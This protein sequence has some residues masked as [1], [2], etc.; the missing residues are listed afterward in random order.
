[1]SKNF[2]DSNQSQDAAFHHQLTR[3]QFTLSPSVLLWWEDRRLF[4]VVSNSVNPGMASPAHARALAVVTQLRGSSCASAAAGGFLPPH[5]CPAQ[6][7][8]CMAFKPLPLAGH[9]CCLQGKCS[10]LYWFGQLFL[11]YF[12]RAIV[13]NWC[14]VRGEAHAGVT[15]TAG[16]ESS[17]FMSSYPFP[18]NVLLV[19][20]GFFRSVVKWNS[21]FILALSGQIFWL[22]LFPVHVYSHSPAYLSY[23]CPFMGPS[24]LPA[25]CHP[26][27]S[28]AQAEA[29]EQTC[30]Q[31]KRPGE[32]WGEV[33][34][35]HGQLPKDAVG[36]EPWWAS[37]RHLR[38]RLPR[39]S[40]S[41][42][43]V[44]L[45]WILWGTAGYPQA[46]RY[47]WS[48]CHSPLVFITGNNAHMT[49]CLKG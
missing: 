5:P 28:T 38:R 18:T 8:P 39:F 41:G 14:L 11:R 24:P 48:L 13:L 15:P 34:W 44:P 35:V 31:Q 32:A 25:L 6:N 3:D 19:I 26:S 30:K 12:N 40:R 21:S 9:D 20:W 22:R 23:W 46:N 49:R 37:G 36:A 17:S 29:D 7:C 10:L 1:M 47:G 16:S 4:E 43:S 2:L 33:P 42:V 45:S 27:P